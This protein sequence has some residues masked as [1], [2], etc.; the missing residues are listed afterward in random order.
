LGVSIFYMFAGRLQTAGVF[1]LNLQLND[2]H[3]KKGTI[4]H[5]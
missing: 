4:I 1:H 2:S 3:R 5:G